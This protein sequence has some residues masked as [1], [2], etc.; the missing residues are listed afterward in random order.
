MAIFVLFRQ[1]LIRMMG[2]CTIR[3][4]PMLLVGQ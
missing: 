2:G 1:I 3:P 4:Q